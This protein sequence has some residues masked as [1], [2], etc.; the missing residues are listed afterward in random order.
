MKKNDLAKRDKRYHENFL[1]KIKNQIVVIIL[2]LFA[3]LPFGIIFPISDFIYFLLC[4]FVR[5]RR[6][7]ILENISGAFP[8][9]NP[10]EIKSIANKFYRHF[11]DL[12]FEGIKMHG[13][14]SRQMKKRIQFNGLEE[15]N[16]LYKQGKSVIILGMHYNNWE[17]ASFGQ[18]SVN[19]KTLMLYN[20]VRGNQTLE[21]F[22]LKS[23]EKWGGKCVPVHK[24][25]R[26]VLEFNR[27]G[28]PTILWLGADQTPPASSGFWTIFLNR[29]APFFSGPEKIAAHTNQPVFFHHTRK[30]G[31]GKYEVTTIPLCMEPQKVA[32]QEILLR[33]VRKMEEVIREEPEYY[34]WSHRRW[35]HTRPPDIP[36][37]L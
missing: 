2:K 6:K 18:G 20:P 17:W 36:L 5:Y 1:K 14:N 15:I 19:H 22:I 32:P 24:S 9:K 25:A 7:V 33:Y 31:R 30:T 35:K 11:C 16:A 21:K 13:M 37:T 23:R 4:Y 8:E 12:I 26:A 27:A 29:E 10:A 3:L 28:K 34:L